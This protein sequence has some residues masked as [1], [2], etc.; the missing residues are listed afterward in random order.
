MEDSNNI[1]DRDKEKEANEE[2]KKGEV[3]SGGWKHRRYN[4][5]HPNEKN[6]SQTKEKEK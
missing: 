4:L 1:K 6:E 2:K 5:N 3:M